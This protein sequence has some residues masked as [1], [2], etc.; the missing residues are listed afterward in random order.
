MPIAVKS[1]SEEIVYLQL[2][3]RLSID[4]LDEVREGEKGVVDKEGDRVGGRRK[5]E[6]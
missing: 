6:R 1:C 2:N 3:S 5:R 4:K